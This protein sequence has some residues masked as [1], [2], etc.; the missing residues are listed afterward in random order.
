MKDVRERYIESDA[1]A[2]DNLNEARSAKRIP[3]DHMATAIYEF[4]FGGD[5]QAALESL[6]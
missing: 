1:M 5:T 3:S 2:E 6:F 4:L